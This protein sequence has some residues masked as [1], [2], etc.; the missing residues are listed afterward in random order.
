MKLK[1]IS[2]GQTGADLAGL[3]VGKVLGLETGG[4]AP[5][6]FRTLVGPQPK[7]AEFGL[8][9]NASFNYHPRTLQNVLNADF[10]VLFTR[11]HNSPGSRLTYGYCRQYQKCCLRCYFDGLGEQDHVSHSESENVSFRIWSQLRAE[12]E[13][14]RKLGIDEPIIMNIAGNATENCDQI[15][16][17]SFKQLLRSLTGIGF[18]LVSP[19]D[20]LT[21]DELA[22]AL[23]DNFD[24]NTLSANEPS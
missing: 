4:S 18:K 24:V 8:E 9:E 17:W 20:K 14:H 13:R 10:T 21:V 12:D 19:Y 11:V 2:G 22:T 1:L 3:W 5:R 6:N 7:L 15:F 16:E 23:K